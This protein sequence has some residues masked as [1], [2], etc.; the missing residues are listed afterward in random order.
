MT[1]LEKD[2]MNKDL[3]PVQNQKILNKARHSVQPKK[4]SPLPMLNFRNEGRLD[5]SSLRSPMQHIQISVKRNSDHM[6]SMGDQISRY[7]GTSRLI[8]NEIDTQSEVSNTIRNL[9]I[10]TGFSKNNKNGSFGMKF[11]TVIAADNKR[12]KGAASKV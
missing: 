6:N 10:Q 1:S 3:H 8:G 4:S 11:E 7:H 2:I 12:I 5:L 9:H